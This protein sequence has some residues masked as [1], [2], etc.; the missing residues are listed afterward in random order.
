MKKKI[1]LALVLGLLATLALF[2]GASG[3]GDLPGSGWWSGEQVQNVSG[4]TAT[5]D[6]VVY[7]SASTA[8]Y[9]ASASLATGASRTFVPSDFAGMPDGFQG[10]AVV[11]ADQDIRAIVNVVNRKAGSW[12]VE[13]G[14]AAAQYQG[15]NAGDTAILFPLAK[16]DFYGKTTTFFIQNAGAAAATA[17]ATFNIGGTNYAYTTPSIAPGAMVVVTPNDAGVPSGTSGLGS[18]SV[19][20]AEP[21]AGV[22]LEHKTTED[23]ATLLQATRAF[24]SADADV[25]AYAPVVKNNF[26]NRLTG[27]QVM[28]P[29]STPVDVLITY[30]TSSASTNPSC[31]VTD[32]ATI[33]GG[34]SW[35]FVQGFAS[36]NVPDGCLA[37]AAIAA[38]GGTIVA[39][40]NESFT[41]AAVAGGTRQAS[42]AYSTIPDSA[43]T[44]TVSV[45]SH[46]ECLYG[47]GTGT[48]IQ[49]VGGA[50]ASVVLAFTS[51]G[52]TYTSNPQTIPQG[53][54]QTYF[55][56]RNQPASFWNGTAMPAATSGCDTNTN[57]NYSITITSNQPI[58]V[59]ANES[60]VDNVTSNPSTSYDKNNYE[61][62][63]LAP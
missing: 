1:T 8:T 63:N 42:T 9:S 24:T 12:G 34:T 58:V 4:G 21:L 54:S 29:G 43:T 56:V 40:V 59:I 30:T 6:V 17:L 41:N 61:G 36:S 3:Q 5:V 31:N 51:S 48:Q 14:L 53:G 15:M 50:D 28:N 27:I 47:K 10:S 46:K 2:G 7:D 35:T 32:A 16:N 44:S 45:P 38:T 55:N 60:G 23:P 37:S 62:F 57:G 39:V 25:L 26:Y 49:N 22:V 19:T 20:S 18:L 52:G 11:S 33:P 13:G